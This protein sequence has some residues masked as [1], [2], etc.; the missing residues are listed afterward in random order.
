MANK[1]QPGEHDLD[2]FLAG[3]DERRRDESDVLIDLMRQETGCEPVMWG[4]SIIGFGQYHYRYDSG[5]EGDFMLVGFSPR[6]GKHSLYLMSGFDGA[7][8]L[9]GRLGKHKTGK[10][11][12]YVNKLG[13]ID[14]DVLRELIQRS[15]VVMR[16]RYQ[17]VE[18]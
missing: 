10:A 14:L 15:L 5:R 2:A 17:V 16:E 18:G 6:K 11:C 8:E 13:D 7:D 4:S 3:L 9:L 1:T 12:L